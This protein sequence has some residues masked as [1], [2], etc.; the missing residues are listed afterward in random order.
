MQDHKTDKQ[1]ELIIFFTNRN[2]LGVVGVRFPNT[3]NDTNK[4]QYY[5]YQFS[6]DRAVWVV[7]DQIDDTSMENLLNTQTRVSS[8]YFVY[9]NLP[10]D[11]VKTTIKKYC[12]DNSVSLI[13]Q[14]DKH[15]YGKSKLYHLVGEFCQ[16]NA[17][18]KV[19]FFD[20]LKSKFNYDEELEKKLTLLHD[21]LHHDGAKAA[22]K[23]GISWLSDKEKAIVETL[24]RQTDNLS[25][26]YI[27]KLTE[28]RISLLGS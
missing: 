24:A 3:L 21:C 17:E 26:D 28:L 12:T 7:N 14:N 20:D 22:L 4:N 5:L 13:P 6:A 15:E 18:L 8:I 1:M 27:A 10:T 9:H 23:E 25:K 19:E 2:K 11:A 16:P